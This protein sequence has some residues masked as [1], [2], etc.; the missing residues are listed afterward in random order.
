MNPP[1][2]VGVVHR[3]PDGEARLLSLLRRERPTAVGLELSSPSVEFRR[4][5]G[6]QLRER[7]VDALRAAGAAESA[8]RVARGEAP[9]GIAG[10]LARTLALPYELVAAER[11]AEETGAEVALLDDPA[12][13]REAVTLIESELITH[14]KV[15]AL[16]ER[17]RKAPPA[18]DPVGEQYAAAMRYFNS[19][20]FFRYHFSTAELNAMVSRDAYVTEGLASLCERHE[21]VVYVC[22]WEHLVDAG[23]PTLWP[24]WKDRARRMLL[25]AVSD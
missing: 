2:L 7:L 22:G 12:P 18:P 11:Y 16:L 4:E 13:A 24:R 21:R 10:E 23:V 1:L 6:A 19:P 20:H 25:S 14:E 17:E 3:D 5:R 9:A 8:E 15:R